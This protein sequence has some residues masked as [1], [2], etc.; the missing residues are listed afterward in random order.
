MSLQVKYSKV[1]ALSQEINMQGTAVKEEN[2]KLHLSGTVETG[3][4]KN[5]LW[6]EI[7]AIGGGDVPA[8]I[9]ADIRVSNTAYYHKH[10]VQK[11][12][13]LSLIAK[14]YFK[15]ANKWKEIHEANTATIPNPN[16]IHPGDEVIIPNL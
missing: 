9:A 8:D 11:G 14:H 4:Q 16:L 3:Y 5:Q 6:D 2:G 7:K 15:D 12:E 13:S 10:T 1:L